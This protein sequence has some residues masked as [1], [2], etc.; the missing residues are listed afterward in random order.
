MKEDTSE[1]TIYET[2]YPEL[3]AAFTGNLLA[4]TVM[5][6]LETVLHRLCLQGTRTI[7]DNTD[8]GLGVIPIITRYEGVLDCFYSI[9]SQE[10]LMGFYKGFGALVLQYGLH[11]AIVKLTKVIFERLSK[12]AGPLPGMAYTP[13]PVT[14]S[15]TAASSRLNQQVPQHMQNIYQGPAYGYSGQHSPQAHGSGLDPRYPHQSHPQRQ[16]RPDVPHR[17]AHLFH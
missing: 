14:H 10:G 7:I 6:P 8:N 17:A 12:Q 3:I 11:M 9:I 16:Y 4:D 15:G 5:Y 2:Y 1:R 13:R